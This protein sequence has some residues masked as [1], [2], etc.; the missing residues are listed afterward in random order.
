M[1]RLSCY[2]Y[3]DAHSNQRTGTILVANDNDMRIIGNVI[4]KNPGSARPLDSFSLREDGR[5]LFSVDATM[6]AIADLF[7][8]DRKYGCIQIFNLSDYRDAD[9]KKASSQLSV[10]EISEVERE[11]YSSSPTYI[12]WGDMYQDDRFKA[13]AETIFDMVK[14][15]TK[16]YDPILENNLFFHPLY[17][18]RYGKSKPECQSVI[19]TFRENFKRYEREI[20]PL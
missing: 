15:R 7:Q 14:S 3:W 19:D 8:L 11:A 12:G 9:F 16:G 4:M 20:P 6:Y 1:K 2:A 5:L 18:M 17:L 13:K 10:S